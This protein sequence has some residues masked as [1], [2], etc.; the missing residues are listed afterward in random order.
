MKH[1]SSDNGDIWTLFFNQSLIIMK[2][3]DLALAKSK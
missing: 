2:Q 3:N 1:G